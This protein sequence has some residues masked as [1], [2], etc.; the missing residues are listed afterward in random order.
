MKYGKYFDNILKGV[1]EGSAKPFFLHP[2][3]RQKESVTISVEVD[4]TEYEY[5]RN[6]FL[7][8][9]EEESQ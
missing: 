9:R 3:K 8:K 5:I 4:I 2:K 6:Q 1:Y 7:G